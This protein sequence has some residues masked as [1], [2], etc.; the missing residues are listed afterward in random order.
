MSQKAFV[1]YSW[2]DGDHC[3]WVRELAKR[4]RVDGVDI[5]F[6]RWDTELGDQLPEFMERIVRDNDFVLMICTPGYKQRF[7]E[8]QGGV[9]YEANLIAGQN[10]IQRNERKFIPVLRRGSWT[11]AAP[12][13]LA[14]KRYVDLSGDP[15]SE[16]MYAE[17]RDTLLGNRQVPPPI[18]PIHGSDDR[19]NP[20][21]A[22]RRERNPSDWENI[23]IVGIVTDEVSEPRNDGTEGSA[24]YHVPIALSRR[25]PRLWRK[26]FLQ[27]WYAG[28]YLMLRPIE[29]HGDRL[30]IVETYMEEVERH[31]VARIMS[32]LRE[33][34]HWFRREHERQ[35]R[36][37]QRRQR[38]REQHRSTVREFADKIRFE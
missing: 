11:D 37:R 29:I 13:A 6:D 26:R 32:I 9:G 24:L 38:N 17:L 15:Y 21:P 19:P 30:L 25:P 2:D 4:L 7:D 1:L 33:T 36:E 12:S 28:I 8:R 16:E 35:E 5:S 23:R 3:E 20:P 18:G 27:A 10:L 34:N 31:H 22:T 14:G